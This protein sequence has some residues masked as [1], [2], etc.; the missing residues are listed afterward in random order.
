MNK[1]EGIIYEVFCISAFNYLIQIIVFY[2]ALD[3][4]EL[5]ICIMVL[6]SQVLPGGLILWLSHLAYVDSLCA[7]LFDTL[8]SAGQKVQDCNFYQIFME[9]NE[10]VGVPTIQQ[11]LEWSFINSNLKF[12]EVSD[13]DCFLVVLFLSSGQKGDV[14]LRACTYYPEC[15]PAQPHPALTHPVKKTHTKDCVPTL[16]FFKKAL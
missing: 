7:F 2:L 4:A 13:S 5:H 14:K 12:A 15:C 16:F 3:D 11:L 10:K 6:Y 1:A 8:R 9:K